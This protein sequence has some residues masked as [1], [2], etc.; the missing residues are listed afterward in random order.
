MSLSKVYRGLEP[1]ALQRVCFDDFDRGEA[2]A[3]GWSVEKRG[4]FET[5]PLQR[6]LENSVTPE[7]LQQKVAEALA[8]GRQE[9][10]RESE[11]RF[12]KST[13]AF[14]KAV[15]EI[16]RLRESLL[17]N[18]SHDML[19]LVLA[20]ARQVLD[21]EATVRK[22]VVLATIERALQAAVRCD[23]YRI[24]VHPDDLA[25]VLE[26]KPLFLAAMHGLENITCEVDPT[27]S[28]GGCRIESELGNVDATIESQLE[29]IRRNLLAAVEGA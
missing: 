13:E 15:E 5:A 20:I 24:R 21:A 17:R 2:G 4:T 28:R 23:S 18:G 25:A 10:V 22:E 9:G 26:K 16:G 27:L 1:T 12:G 3:A 29:E 7:Q 8:K 19:R 6:P 14:G 11:A